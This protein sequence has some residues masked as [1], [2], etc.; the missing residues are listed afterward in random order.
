MEEENYSYLAR[1][2][3]PEEDIEIVAGEGIIVYDKNGNKYFDLCSQTVN[4]NLGHRHHSIVSV[5]DEFLRSHQTYFLSSRLKS[6]AMADLAARLVNIAPQGIAKANVK[7]SNGS[8]AVE[9]AFKRAR[10]FH[11]NKGKKII[12]AQYRSHHGESSET[13]RASGKNFIEKNELG[14]SENFLFIDS[15]YHQYS[16][17]VS[18]EYAI[19]CADYFDS[20]VKKR[21]DIAGF[22]LEPVQV[23]GGVIV[24]PKSFVK[25]IEEICH[26]NDITL[27]VDEVQTAFGW[28]GK[29][30]VSDYYKI[31]PDI[32]A[33]GKGLTAGFPAL[34]ATIFRSEYDN[35]NYGESE[36]TNGGEPLACKIALANI[37]YLENS[38][39]LNSIEKKHTHFMNRLQRMKEK[40]KQIRDVRGLG[41]I[42]GI[43]FIKEG[44]RKDYES[45]DK[46]YRSAITNNLLLRKAVCDGK[47]SNVIIIKPPIIINQDE[48]EESMNILDKSLDGCLK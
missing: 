22:I 7:L 44:G 4:M 46:V 27:I 26:E 8:D 5:V 15:T 11:K 41:L 37:N 45:T 13:I 35:L 39:I 17:S 6:P 3:F 14:G 12:V 34:A 28:V 24:Q 20:L 48:I 31:K 16:S 19:E 47:G 30:F 40:Y 2:I 21:S 1:N 32:I 25:K 23:N 18:E 33:L 42:L 43:E 38:D 29:I 10:R 9:D 36:F